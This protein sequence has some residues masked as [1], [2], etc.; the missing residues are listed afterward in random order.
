[1]PFAS[2]GLRPWSSTWS[3][4]TSMKATQAYATY[5]G[6]WHYVPT[7][8]AALRLRLFEYRPSLLGRVAVSSALG[9]YLLFDLQAGA[10]IESLKQL[11]FGRP[12]MA[13]R[14]PCRQIPP[15]DVG[16]ERL[17]RSLAAVD[18]FFRDL[19]S[20]CRPAAVAHPVHGRRA[21]LSGCRGGVAPAPTSTGC[22][23]PA[24]EGRLRWAT[25]PSTSTPSSSSTTAAPASAWSSSAMR[26]GAPSATASHSM[27]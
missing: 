7:P 17:S 4:T 2:T 26:I 10:S 3:A 24:G 25:T 5:P 6:F 18:A 27:P 23:G 1:M 20:L 14:P 15:A 8:T 22:A 12:A 16:A 13:R 21:A 19:P 11:L 9:R